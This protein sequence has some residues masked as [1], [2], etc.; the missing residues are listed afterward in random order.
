MHVGD[1]RSP[2]FV[3]I[4]ALIRLASTSV[5]GCAVLELVGR[6]LGAFVRH[7]RVLA[8]IVLKS[9]GV[10]DVHVQQAVPMLGGRPQCDV[11]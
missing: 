11:W 7:L 3:P 6:A 4:T 10:R 2:Y 1:H 5:N 8:E 9:V